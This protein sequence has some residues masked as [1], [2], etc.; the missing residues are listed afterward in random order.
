LDFSKKKT[1]LR[2]EK[3]LNQ[4]WEVISIFILKNFEFFKKKHYYE[5]RK[6][7][8]QI[9]W[10]VISIFILKNFLNFS[11]KKIITKREKFKSFLMKKKILKRQYIKLSASFFIQIGNYG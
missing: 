4:I 8:N 11:K 10:K 5:K 6:N 9:L 3:N 2:N 1:S 7:L